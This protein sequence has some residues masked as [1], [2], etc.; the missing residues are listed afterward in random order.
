MAPAIEKELFMN[1]NRK[2]I[3]LAVL[4]VVLLAGG[5]VAYN[6]LAPKAANGGNVAVE[7]DKNA[8]DSAS[9]T[10]DTVDTAQQGA[11]GETP[12]YGPAPDFTV[13]DADGNEVS[14]ADFAG[15]PVVINFWA[16]WCPP[17][18]AELPDFEKLYQET[19]ATDDG[20]TADGGAA[21][22]FLMINL[23]DGQRE[24]KDTVDAYIEENGYTFPV[25]YDL[26]LSATYT[27]GINSIPMT[28]FIDADGNIADYRVGMIDETTLQN[29]LAAIL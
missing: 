11:T 3:G 9:E 10:G 18:K 16:S 5:M 17:C 28:L 15:E 12:D 8:A 25:Y 24:T 22:R 23:T 21:V 7:P 20:T 6:Y 4:L 27:Y 1:R 14:L 19:A 26:D 2:L 13:Y 29:G